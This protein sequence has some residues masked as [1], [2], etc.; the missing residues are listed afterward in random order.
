M[1]RALL[2]Q[3]STERKTDIRDLRGKTLLL[4]VWATWC[5]PCRDTSTIVKIVYQDTGFSDKT[6][7][8]L[9]AALK[10]QGFD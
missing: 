1:P 4:Y 8:S 2:W 9:T 3:A 6:E 7:A 10:E 5:V